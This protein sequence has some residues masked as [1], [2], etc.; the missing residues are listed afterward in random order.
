MCIWAV[1]IEQ[2]DDINCFAQ[3]KKILGLGISDMLDMAEVRASVSR[4][5]VKLLLVCY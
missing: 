1:D 4:Y 2:S 5:I 3:E